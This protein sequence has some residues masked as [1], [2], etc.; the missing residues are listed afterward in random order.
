MWPDQMGVNLSRVQSVVRF[1]NVYR[2]LL[3]V[4]RFV[5]ELSLG[6]ENF[7]LFGTVNLH[8]LLH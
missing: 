4:P 6:L 7:Y 1:F 8:L 2:E 5:H 3:L